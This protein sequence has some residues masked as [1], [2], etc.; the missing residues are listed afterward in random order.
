MISLEQEFAFEKEKRRFSAF[1]RQ[2]LIKAS[3][4][5]KQALSLQARLGISM[6]LS[7]NELVDRVQQMPDEKILKKTATE[8]LINLVAAQTVMLK[9][10]EIQVKEKELAN[11]L[12]THPQ[13]EPIDLKKV[14]KVINLP[15]ME[16]LNLARKL[17]LKTVC[18]L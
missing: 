4:L 6:G 16:A 9:K 3:L 18:F 14:S 5:T 7:L 11:Y 13:K 17:K 1:S 8:P 10:T 15:E 2:N 12:A